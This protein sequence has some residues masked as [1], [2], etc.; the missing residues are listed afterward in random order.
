MI[1]FS[2][3]REYRAPPFQIFPLTH[4]S[5]AVLLFPPAYENYIEHYPLAE[6]RHSNEMK[7]NAAYKAFIERQ[8][9]DPRIAKRDIRTLLSRP[10]TRLPRLSLLL[11]TIKKRTDADHPDQ[12]SMP[13]ITSILSDFLKSTQ[14]GIEAAS[15]KVMLLS[16]A[17]S[18]AFKRGELI[19]R[20]NLRDVVYVRLN[21]KFRV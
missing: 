15:S 4:N 1:L 7:R 19:V 13:L 2:R 17:E 6:S 11:E 20:D 5:T 12:E 18:L 10:V 9:H 14:P 16:V 3:V 8:S 21:A